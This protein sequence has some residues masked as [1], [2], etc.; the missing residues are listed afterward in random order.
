MIVLAVLIRTRIAPKYVPLSS[1][2][3][4]P[5]DGPFT[6]SHTL[7]SDVKR[8][9]II[10]QY[11]SRPLGNAIRTERK[12][13]ARNVVR[14]APNNTTING[15]LCSI[16]TGGAGAYRND[17]GADDDVFASSFLH[18]EGSQRLGRSGCWMIA[19]SGERLASEESRP[20]EQ[21][22]RLSALLSVAP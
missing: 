2:N 20:A 10:Y 14:H 16:Y 4:Q 11:L 18:R 6:L 8:I 7:S 22:L 19:N 5:S 17:G 21:S 1:T 3:E 9:Q 13:A 12:S 15:A